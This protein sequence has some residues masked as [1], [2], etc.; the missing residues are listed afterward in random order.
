M[1]VRRILVTGSRYWTDTNSVHA[2]LEYEWRQARDHGDTIIVVHGDNRGTKTTK[3]ADRIAREWVEEMQRLRL[4][5][6]DQ[7]RVPAD[8]G[9]ACD[10]R[11]YHQPR[12]QD[13]RPYCP[14]AG[15]LRNQD[16]VDR[17]AYVCHAF[18]LAD[19][20]GTVDCMKRA[21]KASI[22]VIIG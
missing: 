3:G 19:S 2:A 9:R 22:E 17:G 5:G 16:M 15:H 14:M 4:E 12:T 13:G 18:P 7:E 20:R 8:W 10:A 1:A 6:V 21:R 11:C